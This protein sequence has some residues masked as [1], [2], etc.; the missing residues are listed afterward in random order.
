MKYAWRGFLIGIAFIILWFVLDAYAH[1]LN[2]PE[3][4]YIIGGKT[5]KQS[6]NIVEHWTIMPA[7]INKWRHFY[8]DKGEACL[9]ISFYSFS[10]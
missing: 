8:P 7:N 2:A 10:F 4:Y 9:R 5:I 1:D 6:D 3:Y